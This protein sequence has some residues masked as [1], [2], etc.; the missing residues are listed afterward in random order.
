MKNQIVDHELL[1]RLSAFTG[2]R[3]HDSDQER[4]R[5]V[6][7]E[8]ERAT[9]MHGNDQYMRAL[10]QEEAIDLAER[11]ALASALIPLESFFFRD[12]GQVALMRNYLLPERIRERAASR[13]LRIWSAGCSTGEEA[14][15]LA[16]LVS[17]LLPSTAGWNISILATDINRQ[18][19]QRARA[20]IYNNWSFRGVPDQ[21]RL[22]Y[23]QHEHGN[24][25]IAQNLRDMVNFAE[26]DLL[27]EATPGIASGDFDLIVCRNVLM[28][29][30]DDVLPTVVGKLTRALTP[31][32]FLLVGH[33]ELSTCSYPA[34][35]R[36]TFPESAVFSRAPP[37][38]QAAKV[39]SPQ[40]KKTL[41]R[42]AARSTEKPAPHRA[43]DPASSADD[44]LHQ[45]WLLADAGALE[46]AASICEKLILRVPLQAGTYYLQ[47]HLAQEQGDWQRARVLLKRVIYLDPAF[48]MAY[49]DLS[50]LCTLEGDALKAS[51]LHQ[52]ATSLLEKLSPSTA[53]SP[54][55]GNTAGELLA[56]IRG[57]HKSSVSYS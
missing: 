20:G 30:R 23:F 15:T 31:A 26:D 10:E 32:G 37:L 49:F 9:H 47:A 57:Q 45:A 17:D 34:L 4:L 2:I 50:A 38:V 48:V 54:R 42:L 16:M 41:A 8:R 6:L 27:G 36:Q 14:Y 18:A 21:V 52:V 25:K 35:S 56:A 12:A 29:Y 46:Q 7:A 44:A 5:A 1:E 11:H 24:W 19:L 28:Y 43:P 13:I 3:F 51:R 40:P 33:N 39:D 22:R 53:L 55:T